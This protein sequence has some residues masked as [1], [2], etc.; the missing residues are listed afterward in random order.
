MRFDIRIPPGS[1]DGFEEP[2]GNKEIYMINISYSE[3]N[4]EKKQS[5]KG[6][7][8]CFLHNGNVC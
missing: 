3:E 7:L 6:I 1:E 8:L 5:R 2:V 4:A